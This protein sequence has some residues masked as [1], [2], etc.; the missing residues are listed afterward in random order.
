MAFKVNGGTSK[1]E[2]AKM[3]R[4]L[5]QASLGIII[6]RIKDIFALVL[7]AE[8]EREMLERVPSGKERAKIKECVKRM[9]GHKVWT[10]PIE[11][12]KE[13]AEVY[14]A[15]TKNQNADQAFRDFGLTTSYVLNRD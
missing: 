1:Y 2:K 5:Y 4:M 8:R 10:A 6:K 14:L 3:K 15:L 13:M 11:G 12:N 9:V 7:S